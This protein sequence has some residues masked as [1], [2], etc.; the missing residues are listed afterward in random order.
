MQKRLD[1]LRAERAATVGLLDAAREATQQETNGQEG[2]RERIAALEK[3]L[4]LLD[5]RVAEWEGAAARVL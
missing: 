4:A 1:H 3:A 2:G 5:V